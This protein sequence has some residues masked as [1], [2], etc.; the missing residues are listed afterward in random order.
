LI[1]VLGCGIG[2]VGFWDGRTSARG[3]RSALNKDG[4]FQKSFHK[5]SDER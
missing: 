4:S 3:T 1:I 5:N 2:I